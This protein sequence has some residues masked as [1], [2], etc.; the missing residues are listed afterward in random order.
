MCAIALRSASS[1]LNQARFTHQCHHCV[2]SSE[3]LQSR[4]SPQPWEV[5][6]E[7]QQRPPIRRESSEPVVRPEELKMSPEAAALAEV[8]QAVRADCR[9]EP[10]AYLDEIR[11]AAAGE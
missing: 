1:R 9:V 10:K 6:M 8:A 11:V 3:W 7:S 2:S 4:M 5:P